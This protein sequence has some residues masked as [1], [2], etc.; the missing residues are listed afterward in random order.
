MK[1]LCEI[2]TAKPLAI[3]FS[4]HNPQESNGP[5]F[6]PRVLGPYGLFVRVTIEDSSG[7]VVLEPPSIR[8]TQKLDP[9]DAKS[10]MALE[11]GYTFGN[12]FEIED[13]PKEPGTY[14]LLIEY[15]SKPYTGAPGAEVPELGYK[16]EL[17]LVIPK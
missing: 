5:V 15:A 16:G 7:A 9:D 2:V 11:S 12:V 4:L 1:Y 8:G 6:V 14:K 17:D 10:Y 13:A 3:H